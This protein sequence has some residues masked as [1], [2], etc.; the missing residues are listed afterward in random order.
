M[1]PVKFSFDKSTN[2][3]LNAPALAMISKLLVVARKATVAQNKNVFH[4]TSPTLF[5]QVS[6]LPSL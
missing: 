6:V 4:R 3:K 1:A 2:L 5:L